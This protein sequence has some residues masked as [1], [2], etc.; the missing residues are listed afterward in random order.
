[1]GDDLTIEI[2]KQI[3]DEIRTTR[4]ELSARVDATNGRLD[5]TN[6]R[7]DTTNQRL[8]RVVQEQI[9][10]AT[11]IVELEHG[12]RE[13][14]EEV[15]QLNARIDS[16]LTGALGQSVRGHESRISTTEAHVR[17]LEVRLAA[18]ESKVS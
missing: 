14:V 12:Q 5:T 11:A 15:K 13:L 10:E 17:D 6:Q 9:R 18:V 1:M 7:L 16:V 4:I 3:R 8:D 2:L